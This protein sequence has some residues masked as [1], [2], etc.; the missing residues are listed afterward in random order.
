[1]N[2]TK[3]K[4]LCGVTAFKKGKAYFQADKVILHSFQQDSTVIKASVK[5][6]DDFDVLV[7]AAPGGKVVATCTCPQVSF[8]QT[9]CQHIAAVLFA[10][11][12]KQQVEDQLAAKMLDLFGNRA[13]LPTGKQ[14]HFDKRQM[15]QMEFTCR[16][17]Y[18][19]EGEYAF[20][21]QLRVGSQTLYPVSHITKFLSA[22][23]RKEPFEY[24]PGLIYT[25]E[26][27]SFPKETDDVLQF[28]MKSQRVKSKAAIQDGL[29]LISASD[30]EQLLPLLKK[31]PAV[32]L[33]HGGEY[34]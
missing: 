15:F 21:I 7:K 33:M 8:V 3:I 10:V 29:L 12:E 23:E 32:R 5:A 19:T 14:L 1:M 17:V 4:K 25:P 27:F 34:L 31:A 30:W 11:E 6:G 26:R 20:G 16:P 13:T 18:Q 2:E 28:L 22:I 24:A 9:Y